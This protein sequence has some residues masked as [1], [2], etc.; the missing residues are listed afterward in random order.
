MKTFKFVLMVFAILLSNCP[1]SDNNDNKIEISEES[2]SD[3]QELN[4][5]KVL[6]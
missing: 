2:V 4:T 3:V 6:F 1:R 5:A